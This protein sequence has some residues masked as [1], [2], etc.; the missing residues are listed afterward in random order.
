MAH[1]TGY[2]EAMTMQS[3]HGSPK[4]PS[5]NLIHVAA[6]ALIDSDGRILLTRRHDDSHQGGL[7]EF[8]GGKL[9]PGEAIADGLARELHEEL[10]I[11]VTRHRPLIR[12]VHH[13]GDR[14]VL[15]DVHR[16]DAW[17][18]EAH[19]R[20]GQ[21]MAWV[22]PHALGDYPMPAADV[23]IVKA[24]QLPSRYL[25]TPPELGDPEAF[26]RALDASLHSGIRLV[27]LR[28]FDLDDDTMLATGRRAVALCHASKARVLFN[29]N[30]DMARAIGADGLHLNSRELHAHQTR[31]LPS[32]HLVAA[33]C[34]SP[35][36]LAQAVR[37]GADFALL[38]PVLPTRSHPDAEPLGWQ[39]FT[40]W[41]D[42]VAMPVYALGGMHPDLLDT[43]WRHGAQ[44]IAGIR[45]LWADEQAG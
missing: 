22:G 8:P 17:Q 30:E 21:P 9:E 23:P 18:G 32:D 1:R 31:P 24:L 11:T 27:Q 36:D 6:A 10:G 3:D 34:H 35:D 29:G 43:A 28:L 5:D 4:V 41:V 15:L 33:S 44:G 19:G 45:G 40:A 12:V 16:V 13:Y 25:I 2:E 37:L 20:E 26:L 42:E 39:R 14:S 38:S 7:W